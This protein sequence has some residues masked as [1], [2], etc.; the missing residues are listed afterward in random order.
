MMK[1]SF[2]RRVVAGGIV[3]LLAMVL[4]SLYAVFM[5]DSRLVAP[6]DW[7]SYAFTPKDLPMLVAGLMVG[8]YGLFLFALLIR[9]IVRRRRA[10]ATVTRSL[11][12][13][14]GYLGFLGLLGFGGFGSYR[15]T[16][17]VSA[18]L[19]F[20][21]FGF[22]GFFYEGKMSGTLKDE[23]FR[24]NALRAQLTAHRVSLSAI[25]LASLL[26]CQGRLFGSLEHTLI[27]LLIVIALSFALALFLSEYLLYRLDH[28][29][30][31]DESED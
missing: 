7:S 27:A 28:D 10:E 20:A 12:P 3:C 26:L 11:N 30:P 15:L 17:D 23:R 2:S 29:E 8:L 31:S 6:M 9:A 18:F 4:A 24:E 22:F 13:K 1:K 21:F 25:L 14:L 5:N 19:F 16:G